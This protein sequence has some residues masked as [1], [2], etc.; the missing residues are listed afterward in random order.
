MKR[1]FN[2]ADRVRLRGSAE[3]G[4]VFATPYTFGGRLKTAVT[5]DSSPTR[6]TR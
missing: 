5:W 1:P 4:T 2:I 6:I 3:L